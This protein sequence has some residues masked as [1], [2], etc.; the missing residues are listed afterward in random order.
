[1]R[2]APVM[3]CRTCLWTLTWRRAPPHTSRAYGRCDRAG[4]GGGGGGDV[5][6][7]DSVVQG[8]PCPPCRPVCACTAASPPCLPCALSPWHRVQLHSTRC[9]LLSQSQLP[10]PLPLPPVDHQRVPA[11]RHP[12]GG[13]HHSGEGQGRRRWEEGRER[14]KGRV[15]E[16]GSG[17]ERRGA[18][19]QALL[20][21]KSTAPPST[22]PQAQERLLNIAR[23]G[24][25]LR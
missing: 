3:L 6:L 20:P 17:G 22:P 2:A 12:G 23:G 1:M 16:E 9:L 14:G 10:C 18:E 5:G 13:H 25:L 8:V 24:V 11:L 19:D 15:R 21:L 7:W 4:P